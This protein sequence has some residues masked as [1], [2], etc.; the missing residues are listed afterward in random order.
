MY[1]ETNGFFNPLVS[2]AKLGY[3]N[4]FE[5]WIFEQRNPES[6]D[7]VTD[8]DFNT[9]QI[10]WD[11]ITL[12]PGQS[13]DFWGIA[14]GW[15][16][17]KWTSLLRLFGY[18]DFFINAGGDIYASGNRESSKSGWIIG[19]ENP[20]TEE[21]IASLILRDTAIATSGSYKRKWDIDKKEYH[22]LINPVTSWNENAIISVTLISP[23]C[24]RCDGFTK[25]VFNTPVSEGVRL[26]EQ[27]NMEGL[28]FTSTRKLLYTKWLQEKYELDFGD[29]DK[30]S[31]N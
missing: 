16:V 27:H 23:E 19:I 5:Q 10:S 24:A 7:P 9:I 2:V 30:S 12:Q 29:T 17:D 4:S 11:I 22:H 14:K 20:F 15:A 13:L 26:I 18:D 28:I 3:K 21:V 8:T 1:T 25:S 6:E 31:E